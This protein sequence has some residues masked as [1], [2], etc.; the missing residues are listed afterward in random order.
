MSNSTLLKLTV[1]IAG[2]ALS[3]AFTLNSKPANAAGWDEL[4]YSGNFEQKTGF[5][6]NNYFVSFGGSSINTLFLT[7]IEVDNIEFHQGS[8]FN[9]GLSSDSKTYTADSN[10]GG[11][12]FHW[13]IYLSNGIGNPL[14]PGDYLKIDL[15]SWSGRDNNPILR[16]NSIPEPSETWGLLGLGAIGILTLASKKVVS[17]RRANLPATYNIIRE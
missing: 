17:S 2:A 15:N 12:I 3:L 9:T 13:S 10:F 6:N 16:T 5:S 14:N 7:Y 1:A 11:N 4:K 8:F